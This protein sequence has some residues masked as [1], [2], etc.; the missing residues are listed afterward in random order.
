MG[1]GERIVSTVRYDRPTLQK[2]VSA[3]KAV[4][5]D[6]PSV[7]G[8]VD[9]SGLVYR[10]RPQMFRWLYGRWPRDTRPGAVEAARRKGKPVNPS[11]SI[12]VQSGLD[13]CHF[14]AGPVIP[15]QA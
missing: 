11:M 9:V 10:C 3:G 15:V 14:I 4:H 1:G 7:F 8:S 13:V 6:I 2:S 12:G 5:K